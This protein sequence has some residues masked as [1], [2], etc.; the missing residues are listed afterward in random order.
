MIKAIL[1]DL[2]MTLIDFIRMKKKASNAAARA[3]VKAG[4]RMSFKTA[5]KELFKIYLKDIEGDYPITNFLKKFNHY[6]E[7]ILAAGINTYRKVKYFYLKP[8]PKVIPTLKAL[9]NLGLK[10]GIVTDAPRLKAF[11]RLDEMGIADYFDVVVGWED[12]GRTKPSKLPFRKALKLLRLKPN[13][14]MHVGDYP[15]RDILGAKRA[16]LISCFASYGYL[17]RGK[18]V[19]ADYS[20]RKFEDVLELAKLLKKGHS[21]N[22][23]SVTKC[24]KPPIIN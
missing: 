12:T 10:I 2:D 23:Y 1:F 6:H 14:V 20:I 18:V 5:Q 11:T 24:Q 8:Y 4:L 22:K 17:G 3:M 13:H 21:L 19:W 16:G 7:R 9:K 15:E